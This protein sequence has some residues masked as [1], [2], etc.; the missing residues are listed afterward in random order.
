[1]PTENSALK[2]EIFRLRRECERFGGDLWDPA[3]RPEDIAT[4]M[5]AK[6]TKNKAAAV[7]SAILKAL[8]ATTQ[9]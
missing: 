4:M 7:A 9:I 6:L 5:V 3:D 1:V 8:K 2:Q